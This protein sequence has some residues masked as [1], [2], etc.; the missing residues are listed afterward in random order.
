MEFVEFWGAYFRK[1]ILP[2]ECTAFKSH[3]DVIVFLICVRTGLYPF[4]IGVGIGF[5]YNLGN[6]AAVYENHSHNLF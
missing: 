1:W 5:E 4:V 2:K 6:E 3:S